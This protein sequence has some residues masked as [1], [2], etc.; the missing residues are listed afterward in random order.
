MEKIII[1]NKTKSFYSEFLSYKFNIKYEIINFYLEDH[2]NKTENEVIK[3]IN[4]IIKKNNIKLLVAEGDYLSLI[5]FNFIK[6]LDCFK[7]ILFLLDDYDMHEVNFISAKVF[8]FV[9][10]SCP[11]SNLR[12]LEKGFKSY[13]VP[14][15]SNKDLLKNFNLE[16]KFNV[17]FF[18]RKKSTRDEYINFLKQNDI[19]VELIGYNSRPDYKWDNLS[20]FISS[21]RIVLN[22][23]NTGYKNKFYSHST[24]QHNFFSFKG[25]P[26]MV[27]LCDTLCV[28]E[29]SPSNQIIFGNDMPSFKNKHE[30]LLICKKLLSEE[31]YFNKTKDIFIK[32]CFEYEDN[33]YFKKIL[34]EIDQEVK[35]EKTLNIKL[36]FWY[37]RIFNNQKV[38][39]LSKRKLLTPY[40]KEITDIILLKF[41]HDKIF[42]LPVLFET[43]IKIPF[44]I[45]KILLNKFKKSKN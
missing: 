11:L 31:S 23:S 7:K 33:V 42:Y 13:F 26:I 9:F 32:R 36:P 30:L 41:N 21:S 8:D 2:F 5:N 27:G 10:T 43:I 24:I 37:I 18:G 39:N 4:Y 28:S 29:F 12:Y 20:K 22:F 40:L 19:N 45:L 3:E 17:S 25:R 16:K 34:D 1:I 6:K 38:R 15:E 44:V 35:Q 14:L